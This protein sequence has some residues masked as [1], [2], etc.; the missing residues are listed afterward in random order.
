MVLKEYL[1]KFVFLNFYFKLS[2]KTFVIHKCSNHV[3]VV[4][5]SNF[6]KENDREIRDVPS[7]SPVPELTTVGKVSHS[8]IR[9]KNDENSESKV[10]SKYIILNLY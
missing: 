3:K 2:L 4:K 7:P 10:N 6:E 1:L 9:P 5:R 8:E